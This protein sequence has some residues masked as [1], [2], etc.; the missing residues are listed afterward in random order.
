[1]IVIAISTGLVGGQLLPIEAFSATESLRTILSG[2]LQFFIPLIVLAF[3]AAGVAELRGAIG[4]MLSFSVILAYVDTV[5]GIG[6]GVLA[7]TSLI[8]RLAPGGAS[9]QDAV[10]LPVPFFD[11]DTDPPLAVISALLLA[12]ILGIWS[13]WE[14]SQTLRKRLLEFRDI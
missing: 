12:F 8:P 6:L 11:L 4:R 7:A 2:L 1:W 5:I 13:T 10:A 14:T 9:A 3:I